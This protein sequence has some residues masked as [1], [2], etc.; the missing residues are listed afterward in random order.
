MLEVKNLSKKFKNNTVLKDI[1]TLL[2]PGIYGLLGPNGAGKTTLI[3]CITGLYR[4][5]GEIR[6]DGKSIEKNLNYVQ[7]VGYVPQK[8]GAYRELTVEENLKYFCVLKGIIK[9]SQYS[10][11]NKVLELVNLVKEKEKKVK[12]LSGGM[13]RRLG[14]AQALLGNPDF[15]IFDEPT[16]GLD[17]EE[18]LNF[19]M[20]VST[21][22]KDKVIII[23]TH[24]VDDLDSLCDKILIMKNGKIPYIGTVNELKRIAEG[25]V[26]ECTKEEIIRLHGKYFIEKIFEYN[27]KSMYRIV[28]SEKQS[29]KMIKPGIEDGYICI[30]KEI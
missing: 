30:L 9:D 16:A 26:Y 11:I 2:E 18:R 24:I 5:D 13:I 29:C 22:S 21:L 1:N 3:R 20:I 25:K 23:S 17:P 27:G 7:S 10:E 15:I 28:A 19:K 6:W 8:F 4:F 12:A 14:I